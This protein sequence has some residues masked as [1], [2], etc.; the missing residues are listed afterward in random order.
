M[1]IRISKNKI[2]R[3]GIRKNDDVEEVVKNFAKSINYHKLSIFTAEI[4]NGNTTRTY[5]SGFAST[6]K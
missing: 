3:L 2:G 5:Q 1:D 4:S 6:K